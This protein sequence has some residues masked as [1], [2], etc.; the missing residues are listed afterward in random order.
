[1]MMKKLEEF[2]YLSAFQRILVMPFQEFRV[3]RVY[4]FHY[5]MNVKR[6]HGLG[7]MLENC[8]HACNFSFQ[9]LLYNNSSLGN[10]QDDFILI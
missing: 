8:K 10:N 6:V 4:S 5:F 9:F 2:Q 1:M 7:I 3:K